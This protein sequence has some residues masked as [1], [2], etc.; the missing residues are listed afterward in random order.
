MAKDT[1][2]EINED[3]VINRSEIETTINYS[4]KD[5]IF[6]D[7]KSQKIK[8]Y[9]DSKIDYGEIN[10]EAYEI[11][12]NWNDKTLDAN[13][14]LD[15]TGKKIG[16]PIF[17]EGNQSYE[18]DKITYNF[19]SKRAKIKGIVTQL[20]DA[21]MQGEDVKKNEDDELFISHAKYT[22]CNLAEPHFHISANKIKVIPGKKVVS[23]PFHLKFGDVPTPL[24][25]IFGMFPQ[26]KKKV[27]GLIMPN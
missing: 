16:K 5:S 21:Y 7:L 3:T 26:P 25:F 11:L 17:S 1:V 19:E 13:F 2:I 24:G 18:T 10:L 22:T 9:G 4:A 15:S 20:D 14:I 12:V 23:G 8:L 27:S 6:Y